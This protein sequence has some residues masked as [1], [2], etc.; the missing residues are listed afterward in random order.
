MGVTLRAATYN[1]HSCVGRDGR[2]DPSRIAR[3]LVEMAGDVMALQEVTLDEAGELVGRLE[4]ATGT[5]SVDGSI[6]AS[7]TGRYGNMILTRFPVTATRLHD[8]SVIG[9][10]QR[11][12]VDIA[13]EPGGVPCRICATH[14]GLNRRERKEQ[15]LRLAG[16]FSAGPPAAIL[17]GDLNTPWPLKSLRPLTAIGFRHVGIAS[18]PTWPSPMAALDL[19]LARPPALIRRCWRHD[20][21][22]AREASDHFP[23]VAELELSGDC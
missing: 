7:R 8:L 22:L 23:V 4:A 1:I 9:R 5:S 2:F 13:V 14:L 17:L 12:V 6:F 18:F 16:L 10:E 19:I 3:V 11:G 21:A 15:M 20:S